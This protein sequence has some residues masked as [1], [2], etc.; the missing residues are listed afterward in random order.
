M[1]NFI[2][3]VDFNLLVVNISYKVK[4][5]GRRK[6]FLK[7]VTCARSVQTLRVSQREICHMISEE[8]VGRRKQLENEVKSDSLFCGNTVEISG[9]NVP[10][11]LLGPICSFNRKLINQDGDC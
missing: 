2:D 8:G 6:L 7:N 11:S 9:G 4:N 3:Q 10:A 1:N 5:N